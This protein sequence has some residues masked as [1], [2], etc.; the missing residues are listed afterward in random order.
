MKWTHETHVNMVESDGTI[1]DIKNRIYK[2]IYGNWRI[3]KEV[4]GIKINLHGVWDN[5]KKM[6]N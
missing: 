6:T 1:Y 2:C 4:K 3:I 5:Q